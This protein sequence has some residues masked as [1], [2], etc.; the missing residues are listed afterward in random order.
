MKEIIVM[1]E[2]QNIQIR[3]MQLL[4]NKK[5][6]NQEISIKLE[7]SYNYLNT[8]LRNMKIQGLVKEAESFDFR[9]KPLM[10]TAQGIIILKKKE[11]KEK[12]KKSLFKKIDDYF[13]DGLKEL[14][15]ID[16]KKDESS[17][18]PST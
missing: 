14:G 2:T 1:G 15:I 3:I 12:S 16:L 17:N 18:K 5:M 4:K 11:I 10:I 8:I 7:K 6:C 9:S 13:A